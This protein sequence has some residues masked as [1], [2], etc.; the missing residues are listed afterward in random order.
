[1][2]EKK[3][4]RFKATPKSSAACN[5]KPPIVSG[6]CADVLALIRQLQPVLSFTLTAEH[7]IPETAAR[8]HDL[9]VRGYHVITTILPAVEYRGQIR[10]NVAQYS[11]GAPEWP[12]PGFLDDAGGAV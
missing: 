10:R 4:G 12:R 3:K 1:M 11:L 9:R 6:Q 7:A 2:D 8:V 5:P